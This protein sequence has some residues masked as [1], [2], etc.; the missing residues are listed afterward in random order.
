M[1]TTNAPTSLQPHADP[2]DAIVIGSGI[3]GLGFAAIMSKLRG[4]R[5]L[6]LERHFKIGGF[7]HTFSRPGGW[8]WD[9]GVHY[10]GEMGKGMMGRQLFDFVTDGNV[11][12][13][14]LPDVYDVFAYPDFMIKV[15]KGRANFERA[16]VEAFSAE[17]AHISQYFRDIK[18]ATNWFNRHVMATVTPLPISLVVQAMN[19]ATEKHSLQTTGQYLE[20]H[21]HDPRLRAVLASQWADY[22]LPPG[23]SAF[24]TH[25]VIVNHYLNGAWYPCGGSGEIAKA[26]S[27][28]I[29]GS[30]GSLLVGH[31]VTKIIMENGKASGVQVQLRKGA[32]TRQLEF[33]APVVVSDA[34]AWNTFQ[35]FLPE[36]AIP[37]RADLEKLP[38]G[39]EAVELFLGLK[40][41][42]R[43]MGF[44]G[45]N[46]WIF[47]SFDHDQMCADRNDL[48]NG[49]AAMAYLSFPSLKDPRAQCHTAEIVAP[50]SFHALET[51]R[52]EPWRR[53]GTEYETAKNRIMES[54]L[55]LV[56]KHHPGFRD[57][58]AY[59]E[60]ATP[61]TFEHFAG[62][63]SGTIY[64]YPATPERFRRKWFQPK[65]PI[66]HLY[67]TGADAGLLGVMGALMGGVA[68]ASTLLGTAGFME[69]MRAVRSKRPAR[70]PSIA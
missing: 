52:N 11:D 23:R 46:Y 49:H 2:F 13:S 34:G 54:L 15:P 9:V 24:V 62:S 32:G 6:V 22:G 17:R 18:R 12:W 55:G 7:T 43:E 39:L 30:G 63:P 26:A 38:E 29:L 66:P 31:E 68:T 19:R 21:F 56:E 70:T 10:V 25:A 67:L 51:F 16:L 5:V 64:G 69:I 45:E 44:K 36:E 8:T 33:R 61:L 20:K 41:D 28:I 48:L 58:I 65:T 14:P 1:S 4:W 53:R 3:G 42:P 50:F 57:H 60:L 59:A 40:R 35:R 27:A 47:S 37:F